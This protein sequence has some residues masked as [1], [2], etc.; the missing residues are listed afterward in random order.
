MAFEDFEASFRLAPSP[1]V[2][3]YSGYCLSKLKYHEEAIDSYCIAMD[4]GYDPPWLLNN[5]GYSHFQLRRLEDAEYYLRQA[6]EA[7]NSFQAA[8]HNLVLV[9]LRRGL[10]G[11]PIPDSALVHAR[12]ALELG[13]PS[14]DLYLDVAVLYA[15]AAKQDANLIRPALE[16]LDRSV[17][18]GLDPRLLQSK[19]GLASLREQGDFKNLLT[20]PARTEPPSI[21]PVLLVDPS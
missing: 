19:R 18:Y 2:S 21:K 10:A 1:A 5:M 17:A 13:P 4:M 9:F 3:F 20:K 16:Y 8:H 6:T 11:H 14:A 12:K 15:L 7:D